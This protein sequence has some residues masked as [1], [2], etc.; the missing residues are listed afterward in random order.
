MLSNTYALFDKLPRN[1]EKK[2]NQLK[3]ELKRKDQIITV[4]IKEAI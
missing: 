3:S 1:A 2:I 4:V